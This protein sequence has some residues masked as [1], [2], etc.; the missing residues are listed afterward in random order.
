ML[1]ILHFY[2]SKKNISIESAVYPPRILIY[3]GKQ[4]LL[5]LYSW[6]FKKVQLNELELSSVWERFVGSRDREKPSTYQ[7]A[8]VSS[9][10]DIESTMINF[11]IN[12]LALYMLVPKYEVHFLLFSENISSREQ[13]IYSEN[14]RK[15]TIPCRTG[16]NF[17]EWILA[18]K[19]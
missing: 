16:W 2:V 17:P 13:E 18:L 4:Y 8:W 7:D 11:W 5:E 9:L 10:R 6:Y 19:P 1:E 14:K 15:R 12:V 3:I